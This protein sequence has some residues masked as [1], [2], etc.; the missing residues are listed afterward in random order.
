MGDLSEVANQL[1]EL[2][3]KEKELE[4]LKKKLGKKDA[5]NQ[6]DT[7]QGLVIRYQRETIYTLLK[8][9]EERNKLGSYWEGFIGEV[10]SCREAVKEAEKLLQNLSDKRLEELKVQLTERDRVI[11]ALTEEVNQLKTRVRVLLGTG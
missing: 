3:E 10:I 8:L 6:L 5:S 4:V 11:E 7:L 9:Q 2:K 1:E